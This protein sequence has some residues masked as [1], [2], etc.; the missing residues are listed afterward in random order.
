M[1]KKKLILNIILWTILL[2]SLYYAYQFY[3]THNFN[4]FIRSEQNLNS[5][6]FMRDAEVKYSDKRSYKITSNAYNDA[7]FYK[8]IKV[9]KNSPYKVTCM[10]K[11]NNVISE[12]NLSGSGAQIS[13]GDTTERSIAITGTQDWQKIELIFN[14][15]DREEVNIGFRLGGYIDNCSGEAWFSDFTIEQGYADTSKEW[16]FACFIFENTDVN[17]NGENVKLSMTP[18]DISDIQQTITRFESACREMSN[19]KMSAKCDVYRLETP[20]TKLS[21]DEEFAYFVGPEDVESQIKDTIN[22]NDYDHIFVIIRLGDDEHSNNIKTNDWIGLGAM[23]YYGIG[24]SNIR[25]PNSSKS[26]IYK[27]DS[28]INIFPE[29]VFL[30]EFLHSLE[31]TLEEYGYDIPALHDDEKYGYTTQALVG[32]KDWYEAYMNKTI[33]TTNGNIG[34]DPIAYQLKPA[35][36]S[37]FEFSYKLKDEFSE[38]EN[39]IEEIR[40]MFKNISKNLKLLRNQE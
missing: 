19:N 34:L 16:K 35:K 23:D 12:N 10:V 3:Q 25:L 39:I 13:I 32:L 6:Q 2:F 38:P 26:Y 33:E 7:M 27:Y 14:S 31:R 36:N 24:F 22:A 17:V 18:N 21:Y 4:D 9:E 5:S 37:N 29:E 40:Q 28:R 30:H 8:T 11:T 15:K 1:N 20:I